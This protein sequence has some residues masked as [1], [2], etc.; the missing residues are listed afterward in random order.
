MRLMSQVCEGRSPRTTIMGGMLLTPRPHAL[1][2]LPGPVSV[3][4][5]TL[6]LLFCALPVIAT[7]QRPQ[8]IPPRRAHKADLASH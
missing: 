7:A 1:T 3:L 8:E 5:F 6:L 2:A 4:L